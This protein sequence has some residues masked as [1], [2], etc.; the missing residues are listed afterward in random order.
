MVD[1][2]EARNDWKATRKQVRT[3]T[4]GWKKE[5]RDEDWTRQ[6]REKREGRRNP[7]ELAWGRIVERTEEEAKRSIADEEERRNVW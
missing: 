6:G 4:E 7:M 1:D 5:R 3:P 2:E